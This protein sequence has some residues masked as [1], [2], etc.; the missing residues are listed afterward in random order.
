MLNKLIEKLSQI[1]KINHI[2]L[3]LEYKSETKRKNSILTP[4]Q[5]HAI[6]AQFTV[7]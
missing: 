5:E 1:G 4:A 2:N 3:P 6:R 7:K